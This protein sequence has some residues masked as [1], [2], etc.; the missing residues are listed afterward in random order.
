M[1][2]PWPC[3]SASPIS[4]TSAASSATAPASP[5]PPSRPANPRLSPLPPLV[6]EISVVSGWV[7]VDGLDGLD[8]D[9]D[10][11]AVLLEG[12]GPQVVDFPE[13]HDAGVGDGLAVVVIEDGDVGT[14][15]PVGD[16]R[17]GEHT[18]ELQ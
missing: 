10:R 15:G 16:V 11:A 13:D 8:G 17:S 18:S 12:I 6:D 14:R 3:T 7:S 9:V 5:R 4:R 1:P 2:G